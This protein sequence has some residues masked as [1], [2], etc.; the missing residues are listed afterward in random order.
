MEDLL[1]TIQTK[2]ITFVSDSVFVLPAV[3]LALIVLLLTRS[4]AKIVR[5]LA[6]RVAAKALKSL[7]LQTLFSQTAFIATWMA[8][9]LLASIIAFP[10]LNVED[11]VAFLGFGSVAIGFAFQDIFKNFFAGILILLQQPFRIGDQIIVND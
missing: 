4:A 2:L 10:N 7:S 9:I 3:I 1:K 8:G 6:D 11:A 5:D